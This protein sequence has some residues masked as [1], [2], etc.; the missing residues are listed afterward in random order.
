[1][2]LGS[3]RFDEGP[4]GTGTLF[5]APREVIVAREAEEVPEALA[6]AQAAHEGGAWLAGF[7][8]YELG[9][10]L[11]EKLRRLM[12][13]CRALPLLCLG[14]FDRPEP[15]EALPAAGAVRLGPP[16]PGWDEAA[17]AA[18]FARVADYIAAGDIYQANLTFPMTLAVAG[19]AADLYAL[20]R[21]SQPVRHGAL[22]DLGGEEWLLSRSP[23]LFFRADADGRI[24]TR[25]MKG[26]ARRGATPEEDAALKAGLAASEKNRAENLM[27]VDLLRN[28][29]GRICRI[30]SVR[31][32]ELF[33]VE[34]YR[35]VHQMTSLVTGQLARRVT[36]A[37][38]FEALHPCGSITGAPKIR[39]MEII[40]ELEPAPR[41][42]YC[43]AIGWVA[44]DGAMQFSVGIRT[45][46]MAGGAVRLGVGG[47]IVHDSTAEDEYREALLKA[48]FLT[49]L[50]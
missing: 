3:I 17:Y 49:D 37:E 13:E 44:P 15:A 25:P 46:H 28:D 33:S 29:I 26:T 12:P 10:A 7:A 38:V 6:A 11:V 30:G 48:R 42:A 14:V 8:S 50:V 32:P 18:A 27:I 39:A 35:T 4:L 40:A 45:L 34:S 5:S 43:G 36:L 47:G 23:E 20:L 2:S 19:Q 16:V 1:M 31:V 9:Y 41:D 24:E 22:I 21:E